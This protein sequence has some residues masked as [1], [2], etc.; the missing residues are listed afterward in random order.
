MAFGMV[1][2]TPYERVKVIGAGLPPT[3]IYRA[4]SGETEE[5]SMKGM[6]LGSPVDY[7]YEEQTTSMKSGD[8]LLMYTDGLPE[9]FN[10]QGDMLGYETIAELL[11]DYAHLP[12]EQIKDALIAQ[13]EL[14]SPVLDDD[15]T[16]VVAKRN[17]ERS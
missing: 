10:A 2:L 1:E 3:Y 9:Q 11:K 6:P 12:A 8:V 17:H 14:W 7:P 16:I 4:S 13:A 5:I 15:V